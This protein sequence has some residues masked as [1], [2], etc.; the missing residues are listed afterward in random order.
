MRPFWAGSLLILSLAVSPA[1]GQSY[2][3]DVQTPPVEIYV[4]MFQFYNAE[5]FPKLFTSLD[6]LK[7][8]TDHIRPKY[9][10]D[11]AEEIRKAIESRDRQQIRVKLIQFIVLDIFDLIDEGRRMVRSAP[12]AARVPLKAAQLNYQAISMFAKSNDLELD[13]TIRE[14]FQGANLSVQL[15]QPAQDQ[16]LQQ[17]KEIERLLAK[18]Y[19]EVIASVQS[20]ASMGR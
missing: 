1:F 10:V 8:I 16:L 13:R 5:E 19:P 9:K 4:S 2:R 6:F 17:M 14:T 7:P 15:G 18:I 3:D 12:Q 20:L 11:P